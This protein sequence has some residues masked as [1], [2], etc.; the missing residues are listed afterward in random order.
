MKHVFLSAVSYCIGC[1]YLCVVP[2]PPTA[3]AEKRGSCCCRHTDSMEEAQETTP[4]CCTEDEATQSN[5]RHSGTIIIH[6]LSLRTVVNVVAYILELLSL[7]HNK[8]CVLQQSGFVC[9]CMYGGSRV[10]KS[11]YIQ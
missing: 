4:H 10:E 3:A 5:C 2:L 7:G 8:T 1:D 6:T 9:A 11:V